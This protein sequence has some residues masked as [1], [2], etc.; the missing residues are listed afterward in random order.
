[1][2]TDAENTSEAQPNV[3]LCSNALTTDIDELVSDNVQADPS[4]TAPVLNPYSSYNSS[5]TS[6]A[7]AGQQANP[8]AQDASSISGTAYYQNANALAQPVCAIY[9]TRLCRRLT[10]VTATVPSL[11]SSWPLSGE[12][13]SLSEDCSQLLHSG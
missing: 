5:S 7:A 10:T 13:T 3:T 12:L 8:Y 1:M 9:S 4:V 2:E 6:L 11:L